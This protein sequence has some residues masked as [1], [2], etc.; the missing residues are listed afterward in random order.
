MMSRTRDVPSPCPVRPLEGVRIAVVVLGDIGRSPRMLYHA[1]TCA[2]HGAAVDL[3][4]TVETP[5]PQVLRG[6]HGVT[7]HAVPGFGL[8]RRRSAGLGRSAVRLLLQGAALFWLLAVRLE[9]PDALIVQTPPAVP[10]VPIAALAARIRRSRLILDWHNFGWSLLA[11]DPRAGQRL[12]RVMRAVE[13]RLAGSAAVNLCVSRTLADRLQREAAASRV[14]IFHDHPAA[15]FS[16]TRRREPMPPALETLLR[17]D[18]AGA[19][20]IVAVA[21]SSWTVDEDVDLLLEALAIYDRRQDAQPLLMLLSGEGPRRAFYEARVARLDLHR[22]RV[23]LL[24]VPY[25]DYPGLLA[26][27]DIG[28]SLHRPASGVDVPMKVADMVGSG[29]LVCALPCPGLAE[30]LGAVDD[31]WT[32]SSADDLAA[33]LAAAA[34]QGAGRATRRSSLLTWEEEW[35]RICLPVLRQL[36]AAQPHVTK[37]AD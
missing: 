20:P 12:I 29:L 3:I 25:E 14:T 34:A 9:R 6:Q 16:P 5:I 31:V 17:A 4:G 10:T 8:G 11:L 26:H 22:V 24:W 15:R 1:L 33:A 36:L 19:A 13:Q 2:S 23:R 7:V 30:C 37:D 27:A 28:I 18:G 21:P 35:E 32:C